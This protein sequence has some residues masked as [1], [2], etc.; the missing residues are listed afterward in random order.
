MTHARG[1]AELARRPWFAPSPWRLTEL[2]LTF[3]GTSYVALVLLG[4]VEYGAPAPLGVMQDAHAYW[5]IDR[6]D[7]YAAGVLGGRDAFLY[8]P[9]FA[10]AVIL[11]QAVPFPIFA[12]LWAS[13]GFGLLAYLR[14]PY[15]IVLPPVA[16]DLIHGNINVML[17]AAIVIGMRYPAAWAP[18]LLTKV[19]PGIGL[20]W[21]AV[22]R[23]WRPLM[24]AAAATV[25]IA[26]VSFAIA[27]GWW[28]AWVETLRSNTGSPPPVS[29]LPVP[30]ALR[31]PAAAAIVV[32]A[33][34][35]DRRWLVPVAACLALPSIWLSGLAI[36]AAC[37][38]LWRDR[39]QRTE[40]VRC[41]R[42]QQAES[43]R[44]SSSHPSTP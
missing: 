38:P 39:R 17:A 21:F 9:A 34:L 6:S 2:A 11:L 40:G 15:L 5:S 12:A 28:T 16:D 10:Q 1:R 35:T 31:L 30:L 44:N 20:L 22:R 19:T 42:M 26:T 13:V 24:I 18:V 23:E 29:S 33:A 36:L 25:V 27:P 43:R 32:F 8:S 41:K 14:V 7:P 3:A 4:V 37:V